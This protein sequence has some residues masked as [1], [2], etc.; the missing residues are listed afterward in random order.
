MPKAAE[1]A[2]GRQLVQ[3]ICDRHRVKPA[4][5]V[6]KITPEVERARAANCAREA[7]G[8]VRCGRTW[9][10]QSKAEM[11]SRPDSMPVFIS[12]GKGQIGN[13]LS[14]FNVEV[15]V[16]MM[17]W[18]TSDG[19]PASE[20]L[21]LPQ[22]LE[23][24]WQAAKVAQG[25]PWSDYFSRRARIYAGKTPKRRYVD[26][27]AGIAGACFGPQ[28]AGLVQY[29]PSRVFYCRAYEQAVREVPEFEFLADL[30]AEGFNLLLLGPDGHPMETTPEAVK[31]AYADA[32]LQFGHE[33]VLVAMLRQESPWADQPL[34]WQSSAREQEQTPAS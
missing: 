32:K 11:P 31:E 2:I 29:V 14:P 19:E 15:P 23:L 24:V 3:Q 7:R 9:R 34:C 21:P 5:W 13:A 27:D 33:R 18:A 12:K 10:G 17:G 16:S 20:R 22:K 6:Q 25:E 26:R 8:D 30:V 1:A 4:T 28:S